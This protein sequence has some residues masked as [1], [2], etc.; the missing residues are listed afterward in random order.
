MSSGEPLPAA[1]QGGC[2][3]EEEW[4]ERILGVPTVSDRWLRWWSRRCLSLFWSLASSGLRRSSAGRNPRWTLWWSCASVAG[5]TIG[6][7]SSISKRCSTT[8]AWT[9]AQGT[10]IS[11]RITGE[12]LYRAVVTAPLQ[13]ADGTL[14]HARGTS[15][16]VSLARCW[17]ISLHYTFD[18]W[19]TW[20]HPQAPWCRYADDGLVH[21]GGVKEAQE[22]KLALEA[23]FAACG[24]T[25]HPAKTK[26]VYCKD[27]RRTGT[28]EHTK[29]T[30]LGNEFRGRY[31]RRTGKVVYRLHGCGQPALKAMRQKVLLELPET[32]GSQPSGHRLEAQSHFPR[33]IAVLWAVPA[34]GFGFC[35]TG[36]S[37]CRWLPGRRGSTSGSRKARRG[38]GASWYRSLPGM[39]AA[40]RTLEN[41][42]GGCVCLMGAV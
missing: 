6:F 19:M 3:S 15:Q 26:I 2:H 39:P 34:F 24:L 16:G 41:G 37:T 38:R 28:H 29:F 32:H 4:R 1:G 22:I 8:R 27:G 33:W 30:F 21:C 17:P 14:V 10:G 7:W 25:M 12:A 5:S 20:T 9:A 13:L 11:T 23:R 35:Y 31:V 40:L 42:D 18:V 36:I